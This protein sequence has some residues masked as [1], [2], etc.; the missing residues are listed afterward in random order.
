MLAA[1]DAKE[2]IRWRKVNVMPKSAMVHFTH[3]P[4]ARAG[5]ECAECHGDVA[6]MTVARQVIDTA[7]MGF[8]L[9]CHRERRAST[10]C[11]ACHH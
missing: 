7:D 10:D 1:Y 2:P 11:V 3:R 5:V 8:C 9:D 6:A 4:H